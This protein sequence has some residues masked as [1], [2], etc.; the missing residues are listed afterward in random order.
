MFGQPTRQKLA[1]S[2]NQV[3]CCNFNRITAV[4]ECPVY[5]STLFPHLVATYPVLLPHCIAC[6]TDCGCNSIVCDCVAG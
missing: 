2:W 5:V 6:H 1:R 4:D 3:G